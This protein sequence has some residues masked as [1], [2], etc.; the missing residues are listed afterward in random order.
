MK[1]IWL[2]AQNPAKSHFCAGLH[3]PAHYYACICE[4]LAMPSE[5]VFFAHMSLESFVNLRLGSSIS[6]VRCSLVNLTSAPSTLLAKCFRH[7]LFLLKLESENRHLFLLHNNINH[8][9][10]GI[11]DVDCNY[12]LLEEDDFLA[13]RLISSNRNYS[14][15]SS[16]ID[17]NND[18]NDYL[19]VP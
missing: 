16:I 8:D 19:R 5:T 7:R 2:I 6:I 11:D 17:D 12:L 18:D 9:R 1:K 10:V 14:S 3:R 4:E 13:K 15:P